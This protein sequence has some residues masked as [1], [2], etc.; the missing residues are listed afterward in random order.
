VKPDINSVEVHPQLS[1]NGHPVDGALVGAGSLPK[2][3]PKR[4][5][6]HV[7]YVF[8]CCFHHGFFLAHVM[9]FLWTKLALYLS[10]NTPTPTRAS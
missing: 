7:I 1:N 3:A 2:I 6:H 9:D 5:Q 8:E 4:L 10:S